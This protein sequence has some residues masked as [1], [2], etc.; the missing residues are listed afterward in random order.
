MQS[1]AGSPGLGDFSKI[2]A[3]R[4]VWPVEIIGLPVR[5]KILGALVD[6]PWGQR[7][8]QPMSPLSF[9]SNI[10]AS[11]L[12][13]RPLSPLPS[14]HPHLCLCCKNLAIT[15]QLIPHA[16]PGSVTVLFP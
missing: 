14:P 5:L 16:Y 11:D 1:V 8:G 15:P 13:N 6:S 4:G 2:P 12:S 10:L 3:N 9:P 7:M